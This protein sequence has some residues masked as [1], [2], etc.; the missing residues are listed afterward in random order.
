MTI[1]NVVIG[2]AI[3]AALIIC[4]LFGRSWLSE[5]DARKDAEAAAKI[6]QA[7]IATSQKAI[8]DRDALLKTQQ[9]SLA[10][11]ISAIKSTPQAVKVIT[12]Q[13]PAIANTPAP[14]VVDKTQ[15]TPTEQK[16]LP[17]APSYAIFTQDQVEAIAK[18]ELQC[19]SDDLAL[20]V[21]KADIADETAKF[22]AAESEAAD[23]KKAAKGTFWGNFFH[24]TKC[25]GLS[26][27]AAAVGG[28]VDKQNPGAGA[29]I[30]AGAGALT[31][32]LWR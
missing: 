10:A 13:I 6:A 18:N 24:A 23:W 17:D 9:A 15:L 7:S 1:K 27:G 4:I 14:V 11:Q 20:S 31:C 26:A 16:A 25:I 3:V 8:D 19:K 21:C 29:A 2:A 5:H 22:S 12:Q 28:L 30:G 32:T